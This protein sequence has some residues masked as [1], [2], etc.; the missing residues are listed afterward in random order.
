MS[1]CE[2]CKKEICVCGWVYRNLNAI[3]LLDLHLSILD[4]MDYRNKIIE[5]G[6]DAVKITCYPE[7]IL[8]EKD[9]LKFMDEQKK[10]RPKLIKSFK[11]NI[12]IKN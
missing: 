10:Y 12:K 1:K 6:V 8:D 4:N 9:F 5:K 3:D 11:E 7:T 2:K